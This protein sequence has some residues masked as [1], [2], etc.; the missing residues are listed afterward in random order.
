MPFKCELIDRNGAMTRQATGIPMDKGLPR[1]RVDDSHQSRNAFGLVVQQDR[2]GLI[3]LSILIRPDPK[4][5]QQNPAIVIKAGRQQVVIGGGPI[6]LVV[7]SVAGIHHTDHFARA[8]GR[9]SPFILSRIGR[10]LIG[11][12]LIGGRGW[13]VR[14]WLGRHVARPEDSNQ[15]QF[16]RSAQ[17]V[18]RKLP[19]PRLAT[20]MKNGI[21]LWPGSCESLF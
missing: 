20:V 11:G 21:T 7:A 15:A 5:R 4:L 6:R 12:R 17:R 9:M 18:H 1:L 19:L 8:A 16:Q 2:V 14:F 10:N 13:R 3:V